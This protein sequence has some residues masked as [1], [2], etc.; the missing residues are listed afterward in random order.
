[1]NSAVIKNLLVG[2][3]GCLGS[4]AV[5]AQDSKP[6]PEL[7]QMV[8][9]AEQYMQRGNLKDAITIYRQA[10]LLSPNK[11]ELQAGLGQALYLDGDYEEAEKVLEHLSEQKA[12]NEMVYRLLAASE[13]R[14][15]KEKN[16]KRTL[17]A[18][19]VHFPSS[20][21]LYSELGNE[22]SS[23]EKLAQAL[24]AWLD[25]IEKAPAFADNYYRAAMLYL[26]S[27]KPLWGL[28][29][30]ETFLYLVHDTTEDD[31][32]KN[33]MFAGYK[34]LFEHI[35][36]TSKQ[37][38][39]NGTF[40]DAVLAT[41]AQLTPVV[42][43]GISTE[44]LTMVRTRFLMEWFATFGKKYSFSLFTYQD[45]LIRS[46]HFDMASQWLFGK[47]ESEREYAA[48]SA[49]HEG[50]ISRY[51]KWQATNRLKPEPATTYNDRNM[52]GLFD[53]KK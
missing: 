50:D 2:V 46:G 4:M 26:S 27:N 52:D 40:E 31:N 37:H 48:W 25:G 35:G 53:R 34:S 10:L 9:N 41:Y 23:E 51:N 32:L 19:L 29:Y 21:L 16:A 6:S 11:T 14:Q 28:L 49:F 8:N 17:Q 12:A 24:N 7:A 22:Y 45:E 1:M 18:G 44:N 43:D 38:K 13:E 39:S 47:A 3:V 36:N 5:F 42:S 20:G 30:G 33:L 15:H